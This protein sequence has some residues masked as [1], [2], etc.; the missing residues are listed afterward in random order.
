MTVTQ[1]SRTRQARES[2]QTTNPFAKATPVVD[3]NINVPHDEDFAAW[4]E[5][6]VTKFV[7]VCFEKASDKNREQWEELSW[8]QGNSNPETL[9]EL[10]TRADA[11][12]AFLET[13]KESY[14]HIISK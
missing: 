9:L 2:D 7:A 5:H 8:I 4:C 1:T 6:P 13:T 11:Y 3:Y 14:E 12:R 10:R